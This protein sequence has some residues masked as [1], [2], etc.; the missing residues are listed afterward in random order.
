MLHAVRFVKADLLRIVTSVTL[1]EF[2][3]EYGVVGSGVHERRRV[4][5]IKVSLKERKCSTKLSSKLN[6]QC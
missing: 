5:L 6:D 3:R 1:A 2:F 4:S